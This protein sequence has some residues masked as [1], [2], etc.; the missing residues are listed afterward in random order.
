MHNTWKGIYLKS[1]PGQDEKGGTGMISNILFENITIENPTQWP[2]WIG[3]QQAS[4]EESCSIRWPYASDH[5]P[6]PW[7]MSFENITLRNVIVKGSTTYSPG[8]ILGNSTNVMKGLVFDNVIVENPN[9]HPWGEEFYY[10]HHAEGEYRRGTSPVPPC[11]KKASTCSQTDLSRQCASGDFCSS[12]SCLICPKGNF[13]DSTTPTTCP[14][15]FYCPEGSSE[16]VVCPGFNPTSDPGA[17]SADDCFEEPTPTYGTTDETDP[18][19]T[20]PVEPDTTDPN[21]SEYPVTSQETTPSHAQRI[22]F[23]SAICLLTLIFS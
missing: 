9:L 13:C 7:G 10:C 22:S 16:P 6:V 3:P 14:I 4:Y 2:I 17:D 11:F 1:I 12:E 8:V 5:C 18:A 23:M 20:D 21:T 15:G 19:T